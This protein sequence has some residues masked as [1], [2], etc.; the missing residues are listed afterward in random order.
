MENTF[1]NTK[2]ISTEKVGDN[3][4]YLLLMLAC[5]AGIAVVDKTPACIL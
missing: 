2:E 1:T 4:L 5:D 3:Q